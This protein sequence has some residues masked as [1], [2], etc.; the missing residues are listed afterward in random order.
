MKVTMNGT[1]CEDGDS[2]VISSDMNFVMT[3]DRKKYTVKFDIGS[4]YGNPIAN[5]TVTYLH[6]AIEPDPQ[7]DSS[8]IITG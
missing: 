8:F 1:S 4:T 2:F 6:Y 7:Y 3:A 5:Q